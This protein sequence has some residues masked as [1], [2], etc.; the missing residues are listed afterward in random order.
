MHYKI[1]DTCV[2]NTLWRTLRQV[3]GKLFSENAQHA[4]EVCGKFAIFYEKFP[5]NFRQTVFSRK[6]S[7]ELSANN[8]IFW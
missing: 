1:G 3:C 2:Y 4:N 6:V 5:A 7:G 8:F